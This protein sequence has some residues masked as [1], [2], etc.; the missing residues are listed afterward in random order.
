[1]L[2]KL[3]IL[4]ANQQKALNG[5]SKFNFEQLA[6]IRFKNLHSSALRK[7]QSLGNP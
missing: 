5:T 1:M 4:G 6:L 3:L 7:Y 2:M